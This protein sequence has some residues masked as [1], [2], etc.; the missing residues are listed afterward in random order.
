M[1][2][3]LMKRIVLF[4]NPTD[5]I[6]NDLLELIFPDEIENKVSA[7]MPSDGANLKEKYI[8]KWKEYAQKRKAKLQRNSML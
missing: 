1:L 3:W 8:N 6:I 7:Y 4:S 5:E 2:K